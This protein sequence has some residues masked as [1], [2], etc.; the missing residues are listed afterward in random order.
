[1][2]NRNYV[3]PLI[4]V[5]SIQSSLKSKIK[6]HLNFGA[7]L[8]SYPK[9]VRLLYQR[10]W[11]EIAAKYIFREQL[12]EIGQASHSTTVT[13]FAKLDYDINRVILYAAALCWVSIEESYQ[14]G[15][16]FP[17]QTQYIPR[18][19]S[20]GLIL[21]CYEPMLR[22]ASFLSDITYSE[23]REWMSK[24]WLLDFHRIS[25]DY[26]QETFP[27]RTRAELERVVATIRM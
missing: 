8:N 10:K 26:L 20:Y 16:D 24:E 27:N 21:E 15:Q 9:D 6:Q 7:S 12:Y 25:I 17:A 18:D 19:L 1:M 11:S 14:L 23:E 2:V 5:G 13:L 22:L 3:P 4:G